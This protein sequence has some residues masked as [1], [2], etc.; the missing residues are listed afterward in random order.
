MLGDALRKATGVEGAPVVLGCPGELCW[1]WKQL[2]KA[3]KLWRIQRV[4]G[5][6]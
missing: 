3:Q 1:S 4:M 6:H 2:K 5:K